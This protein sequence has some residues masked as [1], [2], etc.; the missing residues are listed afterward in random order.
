MTLSKVT[1]NDRYAFAEPAAG[2]TT[3]DFDFPV[4]DPDEVRVERVRAGV[5]AQL[6]R[7]ADYAVTI[8]G[9]TGGVITLVEPT[10]A[11]DRFDMLGD[12]LD[13]RVSD[14]QAGAGFSSG[15]LDADLNQLVKADQETRRD[16]GRALLAAPGDAPTLL[17]PLASL[18]GRLVTG[19]VATGALEA[20]PQT[21]LLSSIVA[22]AQAQADAAESIR[23]ATDA[24]RLETQTLRDQTFTAFDQFDDRYLGAKAADPATDNDGN[25]LVA[26]A[27]YYRSAAPAGMRIWTG[28]QWTAAYVS[29]AGFLAA[30]NNLSELAD[31][32]A[33]RTNLGLGNVNNTADAD[34]PVSSAQQTAL[35]SK[36]NLLVGT[37]AQRPTPTLGLFFWSTENATL[38]IG[39][40]SA[41]ASVGAGVSPGIIADFAALLVPDDWLV[42]NGA[43]VSRTTYARLFEAICP[44][45]TVNMTAGNDDLFIPS[46]PYVTDYR[47]LFG[48]DPDW[49]VEGPNLQPNTRI[50]RVQSNRIEITPT[51]TASGTDVPV[52]FFPFGRGDG[53][54]T[55]TL[56]EGRA[57][58]SRGLDL[59]R[60][61]DNH[62]AFGSWQDHALERH[63]H[64]SGVNPAIDFAG[65][66]A[67]YGR[68]GY[69]DT[70]FSGVYNAVGDN[71]GG[72][73]RAGVTSPP[74][75]SGRALFQTRN[76]EGASNTSANVAA[77][78]RSRS[79]AFL[80]CI[81]T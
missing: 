49:F 58:F 41:W 60:G 10:L 8:N 6:V 40:G 36:A 78:T 67:A 68:Q 3:L 76:D 9:E 23:V 53:S 37:E 65:N 15:T 79:V 35:D 11:G 31:P 26:G 30:A 63:Q 73:P 34:K 48:E 45:M 72:I 57:E 62:R 38:E 47:D 61:V 16:L 29:G 80:R 74:I 33:A 24:L 7:T 32:A 70:A 27:L 44:V 64:W 28:T 77:E 25:P 12:T 46:L 51:P 39:T 69:T 17:P 19:N 4:D 54:S 56:P 75:Q 20:G 50:W 59:G 81:K 71:T 55:F 42:C 5:R 52:R 1:A 18:A 43:N 13:E 14:Y 22:D 2:S 21:S 66:L